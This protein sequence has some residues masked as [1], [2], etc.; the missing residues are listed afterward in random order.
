M[1]E[2]IDLLDAD[3]KY[4]GKTIM[5]SEA[6]RQGLFHPSIHVWLYT[7]NGKILI[8]K[9]AKDK[10]THPGL[11]DVS[12]AG[13]VGAGE[14]VVISAIREIG[15]EIG[16]T[17][18]ERELYKLGVFKYR[19]QHRPDLVDCEF[20]HTFL[21]LLK[22]PLNVLR[23]QESEVEDLAMVDLA[24]FRDVLAN[25]TV[26]SKYVPYDPAYYAVVFR[27]VEARL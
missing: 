18:T 25:R 8:Q 21:C 26:R 16:L 11:W 23:M 9:R 7:E 13:H 20:H 17:V 27:A 12:V 4:T 19:Y 10:D 5:K 15:E 24:T 1:D 6:H 14:N 2:P 22:V 3:G